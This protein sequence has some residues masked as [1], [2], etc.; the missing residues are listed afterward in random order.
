[1]NILMLTNS[2]T[3]HV[4]GVARSVEQFASAF[5]D[6]GYRV[7]IVAPVFEGMPKYED[8]VIRFPALQ[9]F[10]GSDFSVPLPIPGRLRTILENTRF[11]IVHS[12]HPFL[13]GDTALR[14]AAMQNIPLVFTHHTSYDQ[15][16][17]YIP[18]DS[19][20]MKRFITEL[21]TGYCNLCERVIAPSESVAEVLRLRGVKTQITII[22]TGVNLDIFKQAKGEVTRRMLRIPDDAFVVGYVGRLAKEKNLDFLSYA[23]ARFLELSPGAHF[24][25]VG[26]G[27]AR[28]EIEDIFMTSGLADRLH[29]T[30]VVQPPALPSIYDAMNVFAF[31]SHSET[32]GMVLTEAMAAGVPVVALDASGVREVVR[33]QRNGRLLGREDLEEF[34]AA[35]AWVANLGYEE[36]KRVH[37]EARK[38]ARGFSM[39]LS[40]RITL[41]LYYS[42]LGQRVS[43]KAAQSDHLSFLRRRIAR[44]WEILRNLVHA[45]GDAILHV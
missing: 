27:P 11:D 1:M 5:R 45:A 10:N 8:D 24:I 30:G 12:H 7:V 32:Q 13:L 18:G 29:M 33:D 21:V 2:Y 43:D 28:Q 44:E 15:Y 40:A 20:R 38:T 34:V 35:L 16:S 6:L 26:E 14:I 22:P 42:L 39:D 17:H 36:R 37:E 23:V 41:A 25:V 9:R 4:G 3:P 31:A 19:P